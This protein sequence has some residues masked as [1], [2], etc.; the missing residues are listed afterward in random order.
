MP[1][2][3]GFGS[4]SWTWVV[5]AGGAEAGMS[6]HIGRGPERRM[7]GGFDYVARLAAQTPV[8]DRRGWAWLRPAFLAADLAAV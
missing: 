5:G 4:W 6:L 1:R 2:R 3:A 7:G 8:W